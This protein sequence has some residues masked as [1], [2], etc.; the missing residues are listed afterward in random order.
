MDVCFLLR[1]NSSLISFP[2]CSRAWIRVESIFMTSC[3]VW[4]TPSPGR[5]RYKTSFYLR[6]LNKFLVERKQWIY[7]DKC[8]PFKIL[9]LIINKIIPFSSF[10]QAVFCYC[11]QLCNKLSK[12]CQISRS[13]PHSIICYYFTNIYTS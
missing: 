13:Y 7:K 11:F 6:R 4:K 9:T 10:E 2:C 12:V 8:Y 5:L 3:Q 1:H